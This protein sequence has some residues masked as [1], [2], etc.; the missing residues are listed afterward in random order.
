M[1][2]NNSE[3]ARAFSIS[4][5]LQSSEVPSQISN[6]IIPV[7]DVTPF[8]HKKSK[9]IA[10]TGSLTNATTATMFTT[11]KDTYIT[12]CMLT[13]TADVTATCTEIGLKC[14]DESGATRSILTLLKQTLTAGSQSISQAIPIPLFIPKNTI[15]TL[16]SDTNV[17]NFKALARMEGY[18]EE[19]M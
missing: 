8:Y 7:V 14:V 6:T 18:E 1:E 9:C 11:T 3:L 4:A 12:A 10:L 19:T 16:T 2:N 17:A 15:I 5:K 13:I